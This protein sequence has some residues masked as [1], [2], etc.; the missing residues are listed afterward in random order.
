MKPL[1]YR[2]AGLTVRS[3]VPLPAPT[4]DAEPDLVLEV[5][6]PRPIEKT[7]PAGEV[8]VDA[9]F[10]P[11]VRSVLV[12]HDLGFTLRYLGRC[13]IAID[14]AVRHMRATADVGTPA[15]FIEVLAA[16]SIL[17]YAL[18]LRG[19][20]AL[21]ASAVAVHG[22]AVAI[23]G[24]SGSGKSTL[25]CTLCATGAALLA[26]DLVCLDTSIPALHVPFSSNQV[27]LR[28]R[29]IAENL[30][31]AHAA[32]ASTADGRWA[33]RASHLA[34]DGARLAAIVLPE[35]S[36]AAADPRIERLGPEAALAAIG[37]QARRTM[38]VVNA[39]WMA[40]DFQAFVLLA[41]EV[42]VFRWRLARGA[43]D[44]ALLRAD[45][46]RILAPS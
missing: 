28:D 43:N 29:D 14:T 15:G 19:K 10:G 8:W 18:G 6:A 46:T 3:D 36:A 39:A 9:E 21:H 17:S 33:Y 7:P 24:L 16:A 37:A 27:R 2:I 23:A 38:G 32:L 34:L 25:A 1:T 12:R 4:V 45:L 40:R 11:D 31:I 30:G 42:R 35:I 20:T 44:S 26:D 22:R 41:R 13:E 5:T